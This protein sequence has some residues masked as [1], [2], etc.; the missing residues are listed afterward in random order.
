MGCLRI[1]LATK[2]GGGVSKMLKMAANVGKGGK[3]S[4]DI[5]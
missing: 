1:M 4:A 5:G 2:G 3:G